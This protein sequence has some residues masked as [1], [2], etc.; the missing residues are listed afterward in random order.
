MPATQARGDIE[1][2]TMGTIGETRPGASMKVVVADADA[3]RLTH[4]KPPHVVRTQARERK[5]ALAF[6]SWY[7]IYEGVSDCQATSR[8]RPADVMSH[9]STLRAIAGMQVIS[10]CRQEC[11]VGL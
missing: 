11:R 6:F 7:T 2:L 4:R 3:P 9:V 5:P 1:V 10:V 8:D